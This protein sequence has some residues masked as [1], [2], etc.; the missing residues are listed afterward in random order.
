M[1]YFFLR[2]A[3]ASLG[4]WLASEVVDGLVF[5][6]PGSLVLAAVVLGIVNALVRPLVFVLTLPLTI[7][8]LGFFLLVVNG[9]MLALVAGLLPGF[10]IG[11]F[12]DAFWGALVVSLVSWV[13]S[14]IFGP[15]G[16]IEVNIRR[17]D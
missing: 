17:G 4:L 10:S 8:T 14:A 5:D 11:G 2:A 7:V 13:G 6:G 16:R 9:I 1:T 12:W 15:K 3:I